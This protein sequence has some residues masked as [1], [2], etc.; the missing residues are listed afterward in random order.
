MNSIVPFDYPS[1]TY[2]HRD[3]TLAQ[4]GFAMALTMRI[5]LAPGNRVTPS[6]ARCMANGLADDGPALSD[7]EYRTVLGSAFW[8]DEKWV[9]SHWVQ[10]WNGR[11]MARLPIS[12]EVKRSV[13]ELNTA[14]GKRHPRCEYCG[15][16][17][18]R[19][20]HFD[21]RLPVSRGG[22]NHPD[23]LCIACPTCNFS[24]GSMTD[25]EFMEASVR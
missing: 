18:E 6:V 14:G 5:W 16:F 3:F 4:L 13:L 25:A 2:E 8:A 1:F 7:H 20:F 21:H 23:N 19:N 17:C 11:P 12:L 24:K 9:Y 15:G 10:R 22:I